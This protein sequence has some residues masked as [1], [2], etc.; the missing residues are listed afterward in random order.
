MLPAT[1]GLLLAGVLLLLAG[2]YA[3]G[4]ATQIDTTHLAP[5]LAAAV[6]RQR[7][8]YVACMAAAGLGVLVLGGAIAAYNILGGTPDWPA[9]AGAGAYAAVGAVAAV[10]GTLRLL[11]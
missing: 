1:L 4:N 8:F 5:A 10:C 3:Y 11:G 7:R 6:R 2:G 9:L